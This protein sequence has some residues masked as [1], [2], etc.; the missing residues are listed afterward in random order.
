MAGNTA[1]TR[2]MLYI[3]GAGLISIGIFSIAVNYYI[4]GIGR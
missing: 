2:Y 3:F 1:M 4:N